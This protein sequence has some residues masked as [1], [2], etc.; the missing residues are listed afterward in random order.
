M[1]FFSNLVT[2][3]SLWYLLYRLAHRG[4]AADRQRGEDEGPARTG[5]RRYFSLQCQSIRRLKYINIL[6]T[7]R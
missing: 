3:F 7:C 2:F 5:Q 4:G 1:V 6:P